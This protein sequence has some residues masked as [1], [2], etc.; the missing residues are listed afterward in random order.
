[1]WEQ[2]IGQR[3]RPVINLVERGAV[4]KFAEAIGDPNPLYFDEEAARAS[5]HGRLLAPPTFPVTLD[6]GMV[7]GL[8]LP[9]AGLIHGEQRF[10]YRRPLYAGETVAC[11]T[12]VEQAYQK[13]GKGGLL[14]FLVLARI[15][16]DQQGQLI[17]TMS[18]T[19]IMT[20]AVRERMGA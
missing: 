12:L 2:F 1:M 13:Q 14:T 8:A 7:E 20:E 10:Y 5:R 9:K 19:A 17:Y 3:S 18:S 6:H 11:S 4:R 16:E 15:G